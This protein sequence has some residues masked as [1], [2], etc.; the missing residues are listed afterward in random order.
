[1]TDHDQD[2]TREPAL[3]PKR[4]RWLH[5]ILLGFAA[6]ILGLFIIAIALRLYFNDERL[7]GILETTLSERLGTEVTLSRLE[8]RLFSGVAL[9]ELV[10]GPPDGFERTSLRLGRVA[11]DYDLWALFGWVAH[12]ERI[13]IL[14]IAPT[15]EQRRD[16][17]SNVGAFL[18]RLSRPP[19]PAPA[20]ASEP[21]EPTA[22]PKPQEPLPALPNL[23]IGVRVDTVRI[24]PVDLTVVQPARRISLSGLRL[25]ATFAGEGDAY[26]L[27]LWTGLGERGQPQRSSRL[28]LVRDDKRSVVSE[29]RLSIDLSFAGYAALDASVRWDGLTDADAPIDAPPLNSTLALDLRA[30]LLAQ[31]FELGRLQ[32]TVGEQ[33]ELSARGRGTELFSDPT[34]LL[35]KLSLSSVLDELEPVAA[36]LVPSVEMG[37]RVRAS[38]EPTR[39]AVSRATEFS[40]LQTGLTLELEAVRGAFE[41]HRAKGLSG[42]LTVTVAE[43]RAEADGAVELASARSGAFDVSGARLELDAET[44]VSRWLADRAAEPDPNARLSTT[45]R[46]R[47]ASVKGP[48]LALGGLSTEV[49]VAGPVDVP[50]GGASAAPLGITL[51]QRL[52]SVVTPG[53]RVSTLRLRTQ[54][55]LYDLAANGVDTDTTLTVGSVQSVVGASKVTLP[56]LSSRV[57]LERRGQRIRAPVLRARIGDDF[58]LDG[59][60]DADRVFSPTPR[61]ESAEL[62]LTPFDIESALALVP[63]AS[64][65]PQTVRG[66]IGLSATLRG[67][68]PI[69]KL[70]QA[71]TPPTFGPT[72]ADTID[73]VGATLERLASLF[74]AGLPFEGNV[75]LELN[76]ASVT[77]ASMGFDGLSVDLDLNLLESGPRFEVAMLLAKLDGPSPAAD[78]EINGA[79]GFDRRTLATEGVIRLGRLSGPGLPEPLRGANAEWRLTY[80]V[81]G[82]LALERLELLAPDRD[83]RLYSSFVVQ[84][85]L[86]VAR[87]QLYRVQGMPGVD[88]S[89]RMESNLRIDESA[90]IEI[91]GARV[92]GGFGLNGELR[93][94]DGIIDIGGVAF[95]D[96]LSVENAAAVVTDL[97]GGIPF[98]L[99][100]AT[101][102]RDGFVAM[103]QPVLFGDG[104]LRIGVESAVRVASTRPLYYSRLRPYLAGKGV[105]I[106]KI[107]SKGFVVEHLE[108]DGGLRDAAIVAERA[109]LSILGGDIAGSMSMRIAGERAVAGK[110]N[111]KI[112]N[113]DASYFPAL[114]LEPGRDSE[115]DADASIDFAFSEKRRDL[116]ANMNVTRISTTALDRF[117]QLLDPEEQN[118]S[119][120]GTRFWLNLAQINGVAMWLAYEN[121][122]M[123]LDA[124]SIIK[125]PFTSVGFPS[126]ERELLRREPMGE[127]LDVMLDPVVERVFGP[128]VGISRGR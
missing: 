106:R 20:P 29:Q 5:R 71:A 123:D 90:P 117:L 36:A 23:P 105:A 28:V 98:E 43:D 78:L 115:V 53:Q 39:V 25:E 108:I 2:V 92:E 51:D 88:V 124:N 118:Q 83:G 15:F 126:F 120:Q 30:D 55:E 86:K 103:P 104:T 26:D 4:R 3:Q 111:M 33:T 99:R 17:E 102:D 128:L 80:E 65:P 60:L 79:L 54:T 70:K 40:S 84:Q 101:M 58:A 127:R 48:G 121:L 97:D 67:R 57:V 12:I 69:A 82:A 42:Q 122:N 95:S 93:I 50:R 13:E 75:G 10:V 87:D 7:R 89:A 38:V 59:K 116:T 114:D 37:G 61:I 8:L 112:S 22:P 62:F 94:V 66:R 24:G 27:E 125:I 56:P 76:E 119:I 11:V 14:E 85:P 68:I 21:V 35:E 63:P 9:E 113:I 107:E 18:A 45:A 32:V 46:L 74:D 109:R 96:H 64:R 77:D 6:T 41:A 91:P 47:L 16:G 73:A 72:L 110:M 19:P 1:M 100:F 34:V 52:G 49:R 31:E 81:G 44:A